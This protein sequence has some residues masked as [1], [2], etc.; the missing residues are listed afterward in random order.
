MHVSPVKATYIVFASFSLI[1]IVSLQSFLLEYV[2][3]KFAIYVLRYGVFAFLTLFFSYFMFVYRWKGCGKTSWQMQMENLDSNPEKIMPILLSP[4]A[5]LVFLGGF[6]WCEQRWMAYPT[7]WFASNITVKEL[8]CG[9]T[10]K[11]GKTSLKRLT[12]ESTSL[13]GREQFDF[14]WPANMSPECPGRIR[15]V[16]YEWLWGTYISSVEMINK[17]EKPPKKE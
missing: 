10:K 17:K 5:W 7:K 4:V 16:G 2:P 12:I 1:A 3:S 6:V 11:L 15:V 14:P 8:Y 13:D 9:S